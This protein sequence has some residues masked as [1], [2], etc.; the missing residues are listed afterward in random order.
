MSRR[1]DAGTGLSSASCPWLLRVAEYQRISLTII[2]FSRSTESQQTLTS[3]EAVAIGKNDVVVSHAVS[4]PCVIVAER[5]ATSTGSGNSSTVERLVCGNG[6]QR[7]TIVYK[8]KTNAVDVYFGGSGVTTAST[9]LTSRTRDN[10]STG[11]ATS[12]TIAAGGATTSTVVQPEFLVKYDGN[13][14]VL[15][16]VN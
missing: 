16:I 10:S 12:S 15:F 2:D 14:F 3:S 1:S 7:Q 9:S 8:S 6:R 5:F 13:S 4:G 11:V